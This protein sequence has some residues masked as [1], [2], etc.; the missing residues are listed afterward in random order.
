MR[1]TLQVLDCGVVTTVVISSN[2]SYRAL[3]IAVR[4]L[5]LGLC[6]PPVKPSS[7]IDAFT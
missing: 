1:Q 3:I 4:L 5:I 7:D 6:P 2:S